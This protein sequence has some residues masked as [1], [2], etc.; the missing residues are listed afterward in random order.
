MDT[1]NA[2]RTAREKGTAV[3]GIEI[4]DVESAMGAGVSGARLE[5]QY[6]AE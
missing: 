3:F 5:G 6:N 4:P 2:V 1:R